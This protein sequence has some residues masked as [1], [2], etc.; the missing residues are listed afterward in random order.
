MSK[1]IVSK[2]KVKKRHYDFLIGCRTDCTLPEPKLN[3]NTINTLGQALSF[4]RFQGIRVYVIDMQ[5]V[6]E[7]RLNIVQPI[8]CDILYPLLLHNKNNISSC[9][10]RFKLDNTNTSRKISRQNKSDT[11]M[12]IANISTAQKVQLNNILHDIDC[13]YQQNILMDDNITVLYESSGMFQNCSRYNIGSTKNR[14]YSLLNQQG[15]KYVCGLIK[16]AIKVGENSMKV[17]GRID[18]ANF[19][20]NVHN[21]T[22]YNNDKKLNNIIKIVLEKQKQEEKHKALLTNDN[23]NNLYNIETENGNPLISTSSAVLKNDFKHLFSYIYAIQ[24]LTASFLIWK[25]IMN[26]RRT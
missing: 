26:R 16:N 19:V 11:R 18:A 12:D 25:M 15:M 20:T 7:N 13:S 22:S 8:V 14:H 5:G 9:K 3:L 1:D 4:S 17:H 2:V 24:I 10:R 6:E 23:T 21:N